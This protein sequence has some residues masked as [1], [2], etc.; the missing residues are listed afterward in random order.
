[1]L[2]GVA[3]LLKEFE[4]SSSEGGCSP[5]WPWLPNV[6]IVPPGPR[7]P[8][9]LP[10][11]MSLTLHQVPFRWSSPIFSLSHLRHLNLRAPISPALPLDRIRFMISHNPHLQSLVLYFQGVLPN[12]L[13]LASLVIREVAEVRIG[14]HWLL[15]QLVD[16]LSTP[17]L[18]K[19][20]LSIDPRE[21]AEDVIIGL[22]TRS[23][24]AL[25]ALNPLPSQS[26]QLTAGAIG[27]IKLEELSLGY[28]TPPGPNLFSPSQPFILPAG[29]S[30]INHPHIHTHMNIHAMYHYYVPSPTGIIPS[31][32][33]LLVHVP[34]L[35][36]LKVGGMP[37]EALLVCLANNEDDGTGLGGGGGSAGNGNN[38]LAPNLEVLML[39]GWCSNYGYGGGGSGGSSNGY[40]MGGSEVVAK[41][42]VAIES[43]NLDSG[44]VGL[45][46][47]WGGSTNVL[48]LGGNSGVKRLK[49][50]EMH[51][52][53]LGV[54]VERW[55]EGRI[56]RVIC[57]DPPLSER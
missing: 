20:S 40:G 8:P 9:F 42:V 16:C 45:D 54:D 4:V 32:R 14:G 3:P 44:S 26:T 2:S 57:V 1:M 27:D 33:T 24:T 15:N 50:L 18:K 13:P 37:F 19:L 23:A 10:S 21:S 39:R 29:P 12:V 48:G 49:H 35:R 22:L 31:W 47:G 51:D 56:E 43:R 6:P 5:D 30:L 53:D 38:W 25:N 52:C 28:D 55:L 34:H 11:L 36:V 17:K 41:L 7:S 46:G